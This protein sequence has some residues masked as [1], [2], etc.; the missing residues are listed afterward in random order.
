MRNQIIIFKL[1]SILLTLINPAVSLSCAEVIHQIGFAGANAFAAGQ[2]W[3][4]VDV[5]DTYVRFPKAGETSNQAT[6]NVILDFQNT[7]ESVAEILDSNRQT[8]SDL[9]WY[10]GDEETW[11]QSIFIHKLYWNLQQSPF[12]L[13]NSVT[14]RKH[15]LQWMI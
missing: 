13:W 8:H 10:R 14:F 12:D 15:T 7:P 5:R 9:V 3:D 4:I 1:L 2:G 11:H 6:R